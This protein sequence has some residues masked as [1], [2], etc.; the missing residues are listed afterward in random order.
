MK[1]N[2]PDYLD[3]TE[4][5]QEMLNQVESI[6]KD[7]LFDIDAKLDQ[8]ILSYARTRKARSGFR[9]WKPVIAMATC[10]LFVLF[11]WAMVVN[12]THQDSESQHVLK[13]E[14]S[15]KEEAYV[16]IESSNVDQMFNELSDDEL[17][18][19]YVSFEIS[20]IDL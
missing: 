18:D 10:L 7:A 14:F 15:K 12:S 16:Q 9:Y 4:E 19:S 17:L 20:Q 13:D 11:T 3:L 1:N 6:H 2:D 5:E 8:Q